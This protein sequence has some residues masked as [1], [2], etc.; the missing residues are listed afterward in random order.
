[1]FVKSICV[2]TLFCLM[3]LFSYSCGS[4]HLAFSGPALQPATETV[5]VEKQGIV[6]P[7]VYPSPLQFAN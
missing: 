6:S 3:E 5:I 1:M 2:L 7:S 4:L